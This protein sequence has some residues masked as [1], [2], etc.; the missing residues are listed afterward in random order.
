MQSGRSGLHAAEPSGDVV[1]AWASCGISRPAAKFPRVAALGWTSRGKQSPR[2]AAGRGGA[3]DT[4]A[5]EAW[6]ASCL[7]EAISFHSDWAIDPVQRSFS[8]QAVVASSAA[9]WAEAGRRPPRP[10]VAAQSSTQ[11]PGCSHTSR[12]I[13]SVE[14]PPPA[15]LKLHPRTWT[16]P[17]HT[18][19]LT[20]STQTCT[21]NVTGASPCRSRWGIEVKAGLGFGGCCWTCPLPGSSQPFLPPYSALACA[22]RCPVA[23]QHTASG[24]IFAATGKHRVPLPHL[25]RHCWAQRSP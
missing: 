10:S 21:S 11:S 25:C 14:S 17:D 1:M 3:R 12:R 13:C 15:L 9:G 4:L 8:R 24:L 19:G 23:C 2:W 20:G 7:P 16:R 6:Q 18:S 22:G 5:A